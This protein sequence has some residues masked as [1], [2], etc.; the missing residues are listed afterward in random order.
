MYFIIDFYAKK[1]N[2]ASFL[3]LVSSAIY[4]RCDN[5][6]IGRGQYRN[7]E[8]HSVEQFFIQHR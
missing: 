4:L 3:K 6:R 1:E 2:P 5:Y 8:N 7:N